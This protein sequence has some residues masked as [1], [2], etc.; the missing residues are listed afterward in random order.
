MSR[1]VRRGTEEASLEEALLTGDAASQKDIWEELK[2]GCM[3]HELEILPIPATIPSEQAHQA[4]LLLDQLNSRRAAIEQQ[5]SVLT[6]FLAQNH[7][8]ANR[9]LGRIELD[10]ATLTGDLERVV[11]GLRAY[12]DKLSPSTTHLR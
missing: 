4:S 1:W 3:K 2:I 10:V 12:V 11:D 9:E 8:M 5:V 7:R 6:H